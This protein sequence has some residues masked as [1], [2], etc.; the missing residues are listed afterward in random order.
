MSSDKYSIHFSEGGA[1]TLL[2]YHGQT[3]S[4]TPFGGSAGDITAIFTSLDETKLEEGYIE[5]DNELARLTFLESAVATI[6]PEKDIVQ[7]DSENWKVMKV[8]GREGNMVEVLIEK[9]TF[10][11]GR[12]TGKFE[13]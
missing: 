12:I 10:S 3:V 11:E 6:T 13:V 5:A 8:I 9:T 2:D 7:I 1:G 4:Y